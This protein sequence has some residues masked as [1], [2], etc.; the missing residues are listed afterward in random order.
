MNQINS[1]AGIY[2]DE[3]VQWNFVSY[4][5]L[6]PVHLLWKQ[7]KEHQS[8]ISEICTKVKY[9][10]WYHLTDCHAFALYVRSKVKHVDQLKDIIADYLS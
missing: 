4:A 3:M 9:K 7:F 1:Q 2:F 10:T 8:K 5:D 6:K